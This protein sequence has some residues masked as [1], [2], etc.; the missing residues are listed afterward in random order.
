[1][2]ESGILAVECV[3]VWKIGRG[4]EAVGATGSTE[5]LYPC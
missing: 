2:S 5:D 1:M 4:A 3:K